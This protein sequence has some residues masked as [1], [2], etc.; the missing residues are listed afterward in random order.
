M[1]ET[2]IRKATIDYLI[3]GTT[4]II[5]GLT[6][7][8]DRDE[9]KEREECTAEETKVSGKFHASWTNMSHFESN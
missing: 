4:A 9:H 5:D 2:G 7:D 6:I 8:S 3:A 1:V